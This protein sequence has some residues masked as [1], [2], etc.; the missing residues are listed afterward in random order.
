MQL[1]QVFRV[2]DERVTTG[3]TPDSL[4]SIV[5]SG[6]ADGRL[7]AESWLRQYELCAVSIAAMTLWG[8]CVVPRAQVAE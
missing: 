6:V 3:I 1:D 8:V 2:D 7:S 5:E 4:V